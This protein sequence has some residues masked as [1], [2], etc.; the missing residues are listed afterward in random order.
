MRDR[1]NRNTAPGYRGASDRCAL[2]APSCVPATPLIES[3]AMLDYRAI[4]SFYEHPRVQGLAE[5]MYVGTVAADE[6]AVE[7]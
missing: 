4:D 7:R 3:G 1:W 5:M 2:Y 6:Q